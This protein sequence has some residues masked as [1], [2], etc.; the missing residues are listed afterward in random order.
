MQKSNFLKIS[1]KMLWALLVTLG[2]SVSSVLAVPVDSDEPGSGGGGSSGAEHC[3]FT[4]N[5]TASD[6]TPDDGDT[7]TLTGSYGLSA[8]TLSSV[9]YYWGYTDEGCSASNT[10]YCDIGTGSRVTLTADSDDSPIGITLVIAGDCQTYDGTAYD[11]DTLTITV[12]EPETGLGSSLTKIDPTTR[13][14]GSGNTEEDEEETPDTE[15]LC[16]DGSDDDS[17][18]LVDCDDDD[19]ASYAVCTNTDPEA[20]CED[21]ADDDGDGSTDCDDLDCDA[22]GVCPESDCSDLA[23]ND[24]D[25]MT[26]C[27]D[28]DCDASEACANRETVCSDGADDDGDGLIDCDDNDCV[29][30]SACETSAV[31]VDATETDCNDETDDDSDGFTDCDDSDCD[32]DEACVTESESVVEG[33][34]GCSCNLQTT[35]HS[36]NKYAI[37]VLL[38]YLGV[39]AFMRRKGSQ[40]Q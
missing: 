12:T 24:V 9:T 16:E 6:S 38:T 10:G 15:S 36:G 35:N 4:A 3:E 2:L 37:A 21:G 14:S 5:A 40:T 1:W 26:D 29:F 32:A 20:H 13:L 22:S 23:D 33:G 25:G 7:V 27:D 8:G 11:T 30:D 28:S 19:C 18:G 31:V 17:D 34:S 39:M